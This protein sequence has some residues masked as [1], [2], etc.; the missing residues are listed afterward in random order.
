MSVLWRKFAKDERDSAD[1]EVNEFCYDLIVN[2]NYEVAEAILSFTTQVL[3]RGGNDY[4]RR[5]MVINQA[6][7][8]R[9]QKREGDANRLLDTED[10]SAVKDDIAV[11]VAAVRG[12]VDRLV[13]LMEK[14]GPNG[15]PNAEDYR[16]WPVFRGLR[17]NARFKEKFQSVFGESVILPKEVEIEVMPVGIEEP[18]IPKNKMN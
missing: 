11:S 13:A 4:R 5:M 17:S 18:Q 3:K 16:T 7:A 9:L 14:I 12:D 1:L 8:V 10:W 15:R 2:R 6:N